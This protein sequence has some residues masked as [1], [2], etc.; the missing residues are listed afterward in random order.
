MLVATLFTQQQIKLSSFRGSTDRGLCLL[1]AS[2]K[3]LR[4]EPWV[5][6][7]RST[8]IVRLIECCVDPLSETDNREFGCPRTIARTMAHWC[9]MKRS[10]ESSDRPRLISCR[11]YR[12]VLARRHS[13][14]H[15]S[16][17]SQAGFSALWIDRLCVCKLRP[18]FYMARNLCFW[19]AFTLASPLVEPALKCDTLLE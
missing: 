19:R 9:P 17:G 5:Q 12:R 14:E 2:E 16:G 18:D 13:L 15:S 11:V 3:R 10:L 4:N 7:S 1:I 8:L 6:G